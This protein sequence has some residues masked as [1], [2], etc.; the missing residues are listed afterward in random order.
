M[1]QKYTT[2]THTGLIFSLEPVFSA[3]FA[4]VFMNELLPLKGYI[5]AVLIL[6]YTG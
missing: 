2:S 3:L 4:Y 6:C 5:G 1:A